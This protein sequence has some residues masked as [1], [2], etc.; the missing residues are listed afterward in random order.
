MLCAF[1][2]VAYF[3]DAPSIPTPRERAFMIGAAVFHLV[4]LAFWVAQHRKLYQL[5][6]PLLWLLAVSCWLLMPL[7]G[8]FMLI[9][10]GF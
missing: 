2:L 1:L 8:A 6:R 9:N 5:R 3:T 7:S 4:P 10:L